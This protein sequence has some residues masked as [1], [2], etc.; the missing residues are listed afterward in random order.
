MPNGCWASRTEIST[1][2]A[3]IPTALNVIPTALNVISTALNVISTALNVIS[4]ARERSPAIKPRFLLGARNDNIKTIIPAIPSPSSRPSPL[5]VI[6]AVRK[7]S[8]SA[9]TRLPALPAWPPFGLVTANT[10]SISLFTS[11]IS[12]ALTKI[13]PQVRLH[14]I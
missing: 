4:T 14:I 10:V 3:V 7:K 8:S 13:T 9:E 5:L 2:P 11:L 12:F 1:S 6:S